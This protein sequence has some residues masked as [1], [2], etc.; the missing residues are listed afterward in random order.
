MADEQIMDDIAILIPSCDKYS[1]LWDININLLLKYWPDLN[2]KYKSIPIFLISNKVDYHNSRVQVIKTGEDP[3][4]SDNMIL[5]LNQIKQRN[6]LLILDDYIINKYVNEKRL[7]EL[8]RTFKKYNA[9]YMSISYQIKEYYDGYMLNDDLMIK[10][11]RGHYRNSTQISLW[12][13]KDFL[14]LLKP[15]ESAWDFEI[16]GN[17]RT[18]NYLRPF[19]WVTENYPFSYLNAVDKKTYRGSV[20]DYVNKE[21]FNFHPTKLP[22]DP[23][24]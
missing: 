22:I 11:R 20:V 24:N 12:Q 15:G 18:R 17:K 21:G 10:N 2:G 19:F 8:V 23:N 9:P 5:A 6:I 4:W 14:S 1:E 13:K 3:S 7:I 16:I